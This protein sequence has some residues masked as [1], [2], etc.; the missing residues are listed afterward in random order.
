MGQDEVGQ[1]ALTEVPKAIAELPQFS[2]D[3]PP[4]PL[5]TKQ[6]KAVFDNVFVRFA[7]IDRVQTLAFIR[8]QFPRELQEFTRMSRRDLQKAMGYFIG[9]VD[10]AVDLMEI[11]DHN[12]D[13]YEIMI[14]HRELEERVN[15]LA[16]V[17]KE[18]EGSKHDEAETELQRKLQDSF[19]AKQKL[20][21]I[22]I[23]QM[24][25]QLKDLKS[26]LEKREKNSEVIIRKRYDD[27]LGDTAGLKW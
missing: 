4:T 7:D 13:V 24:E 23:Q 14:G 21:R 17:L 18:G 25:H 16:Q 20:M 1:V 11:R 6:E 19:S 3:N 12:P 15:S 22:D 9:V 8:Q 5:S 27:L 26:L 10:R 2:G